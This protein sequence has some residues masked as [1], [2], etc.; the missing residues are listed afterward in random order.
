M[1][2]GVRVFRYE[3]IMHAKSMLVDD[4]M[5]CIGT[6][7]FNVRSLER[8][9]EIFIYFESQELNATYSEIYAEDLRKS[10]ELDYVQF[11]KQTL[12]SRALEA[13]VSLFSPLS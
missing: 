9:D 1:D 7:N 11:R 10:V 3:G 13:V 5:L 2:A 8:D 12:L 4:D 6:V